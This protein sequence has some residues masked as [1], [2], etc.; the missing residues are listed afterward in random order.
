[1]DPFQPRP[2]L[3]VLVVDD[4]RPTLVR[5]CRIL[6]QEGYR[7][8]RAEGGSQ[9]MEVFEKHHPDIVLTDFMMPDLNGA[10]LA[11][12]VRAHTSGDVHAEGHFVPV[13]IF[14]AG[15][16]PEL[17]EESFGAGALQFLQ[18]P[19]SP[20]EL[21]GR[22]RALADLVEMHREI[23]RQKMLQ[24]EEIT[25][26]KRFMEEMVAKDL[27]AL[28]KG[29]WM[30]TLATRRINGD[31]C[32]YRESPTGI[33]HGCLLDAMGHGL[34]AAV[35]AMAMLEVFHE[36]GGKALALTSTYDAM[37][38]KHL[39][40]F[41]HGRF[42]CALLFRLD[43]W[44]GN[45][46]VLNAG[47]PLALVH[48]IREGTIV[49][50]PS[51]SLPL[52]VL[53]VGGCPGSRTIKVQPGDRFFACTDGLSE[54]I[55]TEELHALLT[56]QSLGDLDAALEARVSEHVGQ[57]ELHDDISWVLW[58]VPALRAEQPTRESD[59]RLRADTPALSLELSLDPNRLDYGELGP[60]LAGFLTDLGLNSAQ[61]SAL[62]LA[63][64]E[65]VINAVEHGLL[66][67]DSELKGQY[68]ELWERLRAEALA[69]NEERKVSMC[70]RFF[71]LQDS[72]R[73]FERIEVRIEAL[74]SGFNWR[75]WLERQVED[76]RFHGR[77]LRIIQGL[78]RDVRYNE[79]GNVL[80]F[81]IF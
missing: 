39:Q 76:G 73:G 58:T 12:L 44:Q 29:F 33:H 10:A 67:L 57:G 9:A 61:A 62:G 37:N 41:S 52:G 4:D 65:G 49:E 47:I 16:E 21:R 35:S 19:F 5:T 3:T 30:R 11:R 14:T 78:A 55:E 38:R 60:L 43:T 75:N 45:L 23:M 32:A 22:M 8:V 26:V 77:G 81:S 42:S 15:Q 36:Q 6:E 69:L 1:M 24:G 70:L 48:S 51:D 28:P 79:E 66:G 54:L 20:S 74:G 17:L 2:T 59:S 46:T 56:D 64:A 7:V 50:V 31:A 40:R 27:R 63:L 68:W 72:A 53:P 25:L 34:V 13:M 18:K 71:P 80:S